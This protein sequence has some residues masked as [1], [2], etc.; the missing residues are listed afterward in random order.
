M[1]LAADFAEDLTP[2]CFEAV[3]EPDVVAATMSE[4]DATGLPSRLGGVEAF[5]SVQ[6]REPLAPVD[7]W[8]MVLNVALLAIQVADS[9]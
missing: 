5:R 1:M 4:L 3:A 6:N 7:I 2:K 9:S 8:R